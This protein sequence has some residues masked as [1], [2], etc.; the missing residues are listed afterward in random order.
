MAVRKSVTARHTGPLKDIGE[1]GPGKVAVF[2]ASASDSLRSYLG[3]LKLHRHAD[4]HALLGRNPHKFVMRDWR[5]EVPDSGR[6]K[7]CWK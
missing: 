2:Y 7:V 3:I 4:C 1:D 5:D 6:C